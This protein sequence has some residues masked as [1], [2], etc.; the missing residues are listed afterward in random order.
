[1]PDNFIHYA[2]RTTRR[3]DAECLISLKKRRRWFDGEGEGGNAG[4]DGGNTGNAGNT[5]TPPGKD[6]GN[7][8][9][10]DGSEQRITLPLSDLNE[11]VQR[12]KQAAINDLLKQLGVENTD[13]LKAALQ[14][15][16]EIDEASKSE[17]E[18]MKGEL[19]KERAAR[20]KAESELATQRQKYLEERRDSKFKDMAQSK[21]AKNPEDVLV[22]AK[23]YHPDM[24]AKTITDEGEVDEK[25]IE[26]VIAAM[27]KDRRELFSV[28][29]GSPSAAGG[30]TP[31]SNQQKQENERPLFS[32]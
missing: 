23:A 10:A 17:L 9:N 20:Q 8:G 30:H 25:A 6:G 28:N 22:L 32:L 29:P 27:Q 4:G 14:R 24:M 12:A 16:A 31:S 2:V 26:T 13:T 18:K 5:A 15:L 19:E 3:T 7:A 21:R 11:R 1:M